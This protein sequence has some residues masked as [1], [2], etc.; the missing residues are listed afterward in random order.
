VPIASQVEF[1]L[2]ILHIPLIVDRILERHALR[3]VLGAPPLGCILAGKD[4]EVVDITDLFRG[5]DVDP[6]SQ[7]KDFL[8]RSKA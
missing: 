4:L 7:A 3:I 6:D 1:V 5:V 2:A 8:T